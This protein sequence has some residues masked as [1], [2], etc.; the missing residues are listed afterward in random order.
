TTVNGVDIIA[1]FS[2]GTDQLVL[3]KTVFDFLTSDVGIGFSDP[4]DFDYVQDDEFAGDSNARIVYSLTSG[5]LF[6]NQD[7]ATAG[8]GTGGEFAVVDPLTAN[9]FVI[10]A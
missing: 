10:I 1:D 3:S 6:Y 7:G 5:S 9:D 8:F 4:S 2:T